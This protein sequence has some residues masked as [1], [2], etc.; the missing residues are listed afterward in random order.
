MTAKDQPAKPSAEGQMI[1]E[2]AELLNET[3]LTAEQRQAAVLICLARWNGQ[4]P[5]EWVRMLRRPQRYLPTQAQQRRRAILFRLSG[6][7]HARHRI[8]LQR[9]DGQR[10]RGCMV[11]RWH[12]RSRHLRIG[13]WLVVFFE[14]DRHAVRGV[15]LY[16]RARRLPTPEHHRELLLPERHRRHHLELSREPEMRMTAGNGNL[17]RELGGHDFG[18]SIGRVDVHPVS[19]IERVRLHVSRRCRSRTLQ[20]RAILGGK[21][22]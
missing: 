10:G 7:R 8:D 6:A 18:E 16:R 1:R 4:T 12:H 5:G 22:V 17:R 15:V 2:L 20:S 21:R 13:G 11:D 9:N 14:P 19:G 3:G